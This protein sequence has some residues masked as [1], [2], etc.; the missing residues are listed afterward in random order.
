MPDSENTI[1]YLNESLQHLAFHMSV[2]FEPSELN[3]LCLLLCSWSWSSLLVWDD[4]G[5]VNML[6]V[7]VNFGRLV[8]KELF[9]K[10]LKL[11]ISGEILVISLNIANLNHIKIIK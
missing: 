11:R 9:G 5:I 2:W 3:G 4:L 6:C 10:F 1:L 7:P 8:E